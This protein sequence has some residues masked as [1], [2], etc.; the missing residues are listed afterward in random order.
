MNILST[1]LLPI[2]E[3]I[4][5][6]VMIVYLITLSTTLLHIKD[7]I[8]LGVMIIILTTKIFTTI[9]IGWLIDN[10]SR[11]K[12][13]RKRNQWKQTRWRIKEYTY[14]I[15]CIVCCLVKN[16]A[17]NT[18]WDK[19]YKEKECNAWLTSPLQTSLN[20]LEATHSKLE[21]QLLK[22]WGWSTC[23]LNYQLWESFTFLLNITSEFFFV[24][25]VLLYYV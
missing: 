7:R 17:R 4:N 13:T 14:F 12:L 19:T 6:G 24:K 3:R 9:P 16:L 5:L 2:K 1:I 10:M 22:Y 11:Y 20:F 15:I 23:L 25:Y 18:H 8:N 21:Y